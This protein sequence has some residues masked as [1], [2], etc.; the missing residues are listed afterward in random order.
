MEEMRQS[1][2]LGWIRGVERI[3]SW[4]ID[5]VEDIPFDIDFT[6]GVLDGRAREIRGLSFQPGDGV[7]QGALPAVGLTDEN[8]I[9][10][11][12]FFRQ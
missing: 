7:K 5:D 12:I 1:R 9:G 6:V 8:N 11:S 2:L 4:E 10:I 3:A